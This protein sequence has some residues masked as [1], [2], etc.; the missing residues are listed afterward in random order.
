MAL[1]PSGNT[2]VV[3]VA[4]D[5]PCQVT[6][7]VGVSGGGAAAAIASDLTSI[8]AARAAPISR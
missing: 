2:M 6:N 1:D 4:A 8:G 5:A 7:E 3:N